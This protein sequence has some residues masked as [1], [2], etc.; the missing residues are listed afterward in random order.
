M[1]RFSLS[2]LFPVEERKFFQWPE[3]EVKKTNYKGQGV[4]ATEP[5]REGIIIPYL[6]RIANRTQIA[7]IDVNMKDYLMRQ[8]LNLF[9]DGNPVL[10]T[11]GLFI[12]SLMNEHSPSEQ[13]NGRV[14]LIGAPYIKD[15]RQC[16]GVMLTRDVAQGE[17]LTIHY[18]HSYFRD[19]SVG[20][21]C[22]IPKYHPG[23]Y[24]ETTGKKS[25][26]E[27]E[28]AHRKILHL[29]EIANLQS[30]SGNETL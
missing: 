12:T 5:L 1:E 7:Q 2:F 6:G 10:D 25:K 22:E 17:E 20:L 30:S 8:S 19:Y 3:L 11:F 28:D 18:G 21:D 15:M 23:R 16:L 29:L 27:W 13:A 26:K 4:F 9:Y 24:I 14:L